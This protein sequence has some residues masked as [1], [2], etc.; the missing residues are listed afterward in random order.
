MEK[1]PAVTSKLPW[2]RSR[3]FMVLRS[4]SAIST[5][6]SKSGPGRVGRSLKSALA[7]PLPMNL[8]VSLASAVSPLGRL[9]RLVRVREVSFTNTR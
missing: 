6:R 5:A 2:A 3:S 4:V 1:R 7:G 9:L 8:P